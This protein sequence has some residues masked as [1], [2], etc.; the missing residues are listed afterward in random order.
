LPEMPAMNDDEMR[1]RATPSLPTR[2]RVCRLSAVRAR[3]LDWAFCTKTRE[4]AAT[5]SQAAS[6][7]TRRIGQ[8]DTLSGA[9]GAQF[10]E[11][12]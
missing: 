12:S 7:Y 4:L 3:T 2:R 6:H 9:V 11:R 5:Q 8:G 10:F 1:E